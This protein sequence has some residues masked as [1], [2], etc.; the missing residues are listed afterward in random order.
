MR[1]IKAA[2]AVIVLMLMMV[3]NPS[4]VYAAEEGMTIIPGSIAE[5]ILSDAEVEALPSDMLQIEIIEGNQI[6]ATSSSYE[7]HEYSQTFDF[8]YG[9][10][11]I[12]A[13]HASCIV[14]RYTDGKVHLASREIT[15]ER[16]T[17]YSAT[18]SYGRIVN[19][20]GSVSYTTG[21]SV[22]VYDYTHIWKFAIDFAATPTGQSFNCY[23]IDY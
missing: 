9:D 7:I 8:Y 21:D 16:L 14:Y 3:T 23:E 20:D 18:R 5:R 2:V 19:T 12:A 11:W 1:K 17:S 15:L 10:T 4:V 6:N 22:T 13:A